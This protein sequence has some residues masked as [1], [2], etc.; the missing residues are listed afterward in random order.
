MARCSICGAPAIAYV[1]Y[2]K[3]YY[4][5]EHFAEFVEGKVERT[6][7]KYKMLGGGDRV[8]AAVS[9]GKDS[10]T[11]LS[12]LSR[13][14]EKMGFELY[15]FHIDLGIGDYSVE[16]RKAA[17]ELAR[18]L[19]VPL[20]VFSLREELGYGVPEAAMRLR[21][22][23]CSVCGIFKRYLYNAV[24]VELGAK[25]A[26]GHNADDLAA[27]SPEELPLPGARGYWQARPRAG[28]G[29]GPRRH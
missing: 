18:R 17:V 11:L 16:S 5:P 15:A 7:E 1:S 27:Y 21:R 22:P 8:V 28:G 13:L 20:V 4:C 23:A 3:R 14:R 24:G 29:P 19:G 25:I 10:A 12:T 9:G 6:I 26:T 2:Q